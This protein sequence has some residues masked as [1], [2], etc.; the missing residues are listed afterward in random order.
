MHVCMLIPVCMYCLCMRVIVHDYS[1]LCN[2]TS[3]ISIYTYT[4]MH[5]EVHRRVLI[6][7][8]G[9]TGQFHIETSRWRQVPRE[10]C[11]GYCV[12]FSHEQ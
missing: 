2:I 12:D 4:Y 8:S 10:L 5:S 11:V 3:K 9:G 1:T 6:Q 7:L